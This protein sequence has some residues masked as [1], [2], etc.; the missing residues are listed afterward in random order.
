MTQPIEHLSTFALVLSRSLVTVL[1]TLRTWDR[2]AWLRAALVETVLLLAVAALAAWL[3]AR[4]AA[5]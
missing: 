2:A 4:R 1:F 5:R 3:L